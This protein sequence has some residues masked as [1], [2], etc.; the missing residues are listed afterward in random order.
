MQNDSRYNSSDI[1]DI[2]QRLSFENSSSF[3][4][5]AIIDSTFAQRN[6]IEGDWDPKDFLK[7]K[8]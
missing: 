3:S 1:F 4:A 8:M 7:I 6:I 2:L 5:S